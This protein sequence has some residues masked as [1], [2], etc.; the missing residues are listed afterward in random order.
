M[1]IILVIKKT[2]K[3]GKSTI[4]SENLVLIEGAEHS[5]YLAH[6]LRKLIDDIRD[7]GTSRTTAFHTKQLLF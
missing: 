2:C 5:I 1:S 6:I 7:G 3:E 4:S